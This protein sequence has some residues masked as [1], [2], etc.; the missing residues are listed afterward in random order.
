MAMNGVMWTVSAGCW[1]L[2]VLTDVPNFCFDFELLFST[3]K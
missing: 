3:L 1:P 2:A